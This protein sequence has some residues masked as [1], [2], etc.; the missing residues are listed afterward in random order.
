METT[1][2]TTTIVV[3]N[4]LKEAFDA[5]NNVRGWWQGEIEGNSEKLND[6]FAYTMATIHYSKQKLIESVPNEK[7]VWLVTDSNLS[8]FKDKSEWTGTKI[9][10]EISEINNKTQVRFTHI[11]LTPKFECYGDCSWLGEHLSSK[12]FSA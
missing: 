4:S 2:F 5:I 10:F 3:D 7:I 8:S 9:I 6:E 12:A 11:G 1:N